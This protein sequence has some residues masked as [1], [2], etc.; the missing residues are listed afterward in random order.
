M[1]VAVLDQPIY[2]ISAENPQFTSPQMTPQIFLCYYYYGAL[3]RI[4]RKEYPQAMQ[5]LLV[6]LT[7][8]ASCLSAIQSDAYKKYALLSLKVHGELQQLPV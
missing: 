3:I 1:G 4:G 8:P 6:A 2:D 7:C 5:L